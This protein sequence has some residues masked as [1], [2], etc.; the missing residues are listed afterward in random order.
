MQNKK[1]ELLIIISFA[2]ISILLWDT[3]VI[4]PIKL[5]V[6][7]IHEM[8]HGIFAILSGGEIVEIKIT[9]TLGGTCVTRGG[10]SFIIATAGYLGSLLF[11]AML[12]MSAYKRNVSLW[13]C[14]ILV[15]LLIIFAANFITGTLG[16]LFALSFAI[17][18]LISTKFFN[19]KVHSYIMKFFGLVSC[20][21]VIID[22][23]EDLL[24]TEYFDSDAQTLAYL[25]DIPPIVWGVLWL[26]ISIFVV[27]KLFKYS[28]KNVG[29]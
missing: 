28:Y 25:T 11:G 22:I 7:L 21:Y 3:F 10:S 24:T 6:V 1:L 26:A 2:L 29:I 16:I 18:L 13:T 19:K 12:F 23:K 17:L 27:Y 8:S 15:V 5:F 14:G 4:Y 20:L 9:E